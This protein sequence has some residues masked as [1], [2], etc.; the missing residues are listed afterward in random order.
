MGL[1]AKVESWWNADDWRRI[2]G[3][4]LKFG[5]IEAGI[6][7]LTVLTINLLS[8]TVLSVSIVPRFPTVERT[9]FLSGLTFVLVYK[10]VTCNFVRTS[11]EE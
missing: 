9:R 10:V 4:I 6:A 7:V 3:G 11:D 1:L 2:V 8:K 5:V